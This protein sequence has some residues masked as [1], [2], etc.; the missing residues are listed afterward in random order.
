MNGNIDKRRIKSN[1]RRRGANC[2]TNGNSTDTEAERS[3]HTKMEQDKMNKQ[4][5]N[6]RKQASGREDEW[7]KTD[8]EKQKHLLLMN[9]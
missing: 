4:T 3:G 8:P 6:T 7:K 2:G 1:G 5:D 9:H